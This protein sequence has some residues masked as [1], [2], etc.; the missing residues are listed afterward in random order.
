MKP[1]T[2]RIAALVKQD[3]YEQFGDR[4]EFEP[5][6]AEKRIFYG[7]D[8]TEEYYAVWVGYS[9]CSEPPDSKI[10]IGVSRRIR[11]GLLEMGLTDVATD[12]IPAD[13]FVMIREMAG[14]GS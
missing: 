11:E 7:Y 13:E 12:I 8:E 1:D 4:Y 6:V 14:Y 2:D 9:G 5:V 3:L 10:I